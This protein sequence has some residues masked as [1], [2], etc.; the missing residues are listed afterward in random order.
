MPDP[1][2]AAIINLMFVGDV[3]RSVVTA[4]GDTT[5]DL[6]TIVT[7]GYACTIARCW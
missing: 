3:L 6:S 4:T 2:K 7:S 5:T 1:H